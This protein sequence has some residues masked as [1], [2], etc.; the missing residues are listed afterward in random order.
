MT[1]TGSFPVNNV[2]KTMIAADFG[3]SAEYFCVMFDQSNGKYYIYSLKGSVSSNFA[4][5][6]RE[7]LN[8]PE[9][10]TAT[11]FAT[12]SL[13][14][15]MYYASANKIYLHD[16]NANSS[17]L[18]YTFPSGTVIKD[19]KMFKYPRKQSALQNDPLY[20][21][22]LVVGV[23]NGSDG[24]VY[25]LDLTNLGAVVN[26]TFSK[27]FTGFGQIAQLNYRNQQ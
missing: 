2:G 7:I 25:Y 24:E 12:S 17:T 3:P 13:L 1:G 23:D 19:M 21:K 22:R 6:N 20:N 27:K 26:N 10:A 18:V 14:P 15:H 5:I 9:I 11:S 16:I 4:G 8:S